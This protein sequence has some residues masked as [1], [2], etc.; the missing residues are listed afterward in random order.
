MEGK[1]FSTKLDGREHSW[2]YHQASQQGAEA[3]VLSPQIPSE[4][5]PHAL[6]NWLPKADAAEV[7][8]FFSQSTWNFLH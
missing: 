1:L 7:V 2:V 4:E 5:I 8:G 6:E 3:F